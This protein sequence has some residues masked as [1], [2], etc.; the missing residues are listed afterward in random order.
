MASKDGKI[1]STAQL[2]RAVLVASRRLSVAAQADPERIASYMRLSGDL[3]V[4]ASIEEI[5]E[6]LK[7]LEKLKVG[8]N[9]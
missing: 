2:A 1:I 5:N 4:N 9:S 7:H 8:S 6:A 3:K